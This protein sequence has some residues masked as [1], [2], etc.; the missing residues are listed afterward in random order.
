MVA[1]KLP[2]LSRKGVPLMYLV[3]VRLPIDRLSS[4]TP[5]H[6]VRRAR[7]IN[8]TLA[9]DVDEYGSMQCVE[10][11]SIGV[12]STTYV[13]EGSPIWIMKSRMTR[14]MSVLS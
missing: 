14:W 5:A 9:Q 12:K 7:T 4:F 1:L 2:T 3:P 8:P 13:P 11:I 6:E 10:I